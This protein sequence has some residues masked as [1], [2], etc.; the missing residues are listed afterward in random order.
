M[1][2]KHIVKH[3]APAEPQ[4]GVVHAAILIASATCALLAAGCAPKPP[5]VIGLKPVAPLAEK[6]SQV[7]TLR[8]TFYW[9]RFP[10]AKDLEE[11]APHAGERIAAVSYELRLWKVGKEFPEE[12]GIGR[13]Y[14]YK[15]S[16]EH[17]CRDT[18]P[19]ELV[20]SKQGLVNSKHILETP[21]RPNSLY[22]WTVRAHFTLDG[23]R[24]AT[25]WSEQL[26]T[27]GLYGN[28]EFASR[29]DGCSYP[30][31]FHLIRTP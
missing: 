14:D 15:Y 25:E 26:P 27:F 6:E 4:W 22:F 9:Q 10:R 30:A 21:L 18:D 7:D 20:Y 11:L 13:A 24:R 2:R 23:K 28:L 5:Y 3:A 12:G 1:G 29:N 16:W 19:G 17:E 8:P 31:T